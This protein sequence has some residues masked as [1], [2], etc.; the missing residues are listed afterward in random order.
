MTIQRV[1]IRHEKRMSDNDNFLAAFLS[2][3]PEAQARIRAQWELA[4]PQVVRAPG[5]TANV[6]GNAR[7]DGPA[8]GVHLGQMI[9]GH[10][11]RDDE[12]H[13]LVRY[14]D[15]EL[16]IGLVTIIATFGI[17]LIHPRREGR[18]PHQ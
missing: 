12:W 8:V 16:R 4:S 5:G 9:Y 11:P 14:L 2:L 17:T 1:G 10:A 18:R 6:E 13:H 7:V 3:S 15:H